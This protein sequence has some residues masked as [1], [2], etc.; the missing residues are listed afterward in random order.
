MVVICYAS[1]IIGYDGK[2]SELCDTLLYMKQDIGS[3]EE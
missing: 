1:N 3:V 2:R